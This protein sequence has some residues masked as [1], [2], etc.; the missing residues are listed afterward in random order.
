MA[1]SRDDL[2]AKVRALRDE[3]ER[4][5][6]E[7]R[8]TPGLQAVRDRFLGRKS[9]AVTALLKTLGQLADQS[10]KAGGRELN[11]LRDEMESRLASLASRSAT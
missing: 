4:A 6:G 11:A 8:D 5:L 7:V 3:F 2:R 10:R 1:D 9:G